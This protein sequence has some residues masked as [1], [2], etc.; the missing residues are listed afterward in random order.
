M[1]IDPM[2]SEKDEKR[3][4][5]GIHIEEKQVDQAAHFSLGRELDPEEALRV[6]RKID[7]HILPMMCDYRLI[8]DDL[9]LEIIYNNRVQFMDKTTPGN[10]AI[11]GIRTDTHLTANDSYIQ[12]LSAGVYNLTYLTIDGVLDTG[13]NNAWNFGIGVHQFLGYGSPAP[14]AL[15][16]SGHKLAILTIFCRASS[17]YFEVDTFSHEGLIV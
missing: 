14:T 2:Q 10:S 12:R 17:H 15:G 5:H 6:R 16:W 8:N 3:A 1:S 4:H 7:R 13:V 9:G 11:L